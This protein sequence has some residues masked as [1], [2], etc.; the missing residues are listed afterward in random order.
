MPVRALNLYYARDASARAQVRTTR[1]RATDVRERIGI[2]RG[3]V[4]T[5]AQADGDL[6]D[7]MWDCPFED[8]TMHDQDMQARAASVDFEACR[9][10]MRTL[11]RRFE[12][13]LYELQTAM[14]TPPDVAPGERLIQIWLAGDQKPDFDALRSTATIVLRRGDDNKRLPDW[15]VELPANS[16]SEHTIDPWIARHPSLQATRVV[17]QRLA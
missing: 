6:P 12:R 15:I 3:R 16:V 5:S 8:A 11:T 10:L 2:S 17:W 9:A 7:V 4:F 1:L 14:T 13:V